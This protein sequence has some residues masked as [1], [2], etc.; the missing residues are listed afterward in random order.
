[1][2]RKKILIVISNLKI[3]GGAQ[4][5]ASLL[6]TEI[7]YLYDVNILTFYDFKDCYKYSGRYISLNENN[8][9]FKLFLRPFK[10]YKFIKKNSPDIIISFMD[11]VN[12]L[13]A[14]IKIIF[15]LKT[16]LLFSIQ[17]NPLYQHKGI[18]SYIN[19]LIKIFYLVALSLFSC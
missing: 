15:R 10:L 12:V 5:M 9:K 4:R 14:F 11:H 7:S 6:S 8:N 16:P 3:G 1:M 18:T 19:L 17:N 2:P 13:V